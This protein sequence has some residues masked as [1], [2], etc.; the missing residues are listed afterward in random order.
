MS[1]VLETLKPLEAAAKE[2]TVMVE[3]STA[4]MTARDYLESL[5]KEQR[6]RVLSCG[7]H[8]NPI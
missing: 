2:V 6:D 3:E 4:T 8:K 7:R 1:R 5:P